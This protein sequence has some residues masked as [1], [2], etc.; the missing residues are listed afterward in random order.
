[1]RKR[2]YCRTRH[3]TLGLLFVIT[4]ACVGGFPSSTEARITKIVISRVESPTF[5]GIAFGDVGQYEK[6]VGRAFGEVDPNDPRNTVITDIALAPRNADG[7]VEYST[8]VYI[9]RPVDPS[10]GNHRIFFEI[11]QRGGNISF[12]QM[13]EAT[14]GG[15]DPTTAGDAG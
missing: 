10:R 3:G 7:M 14:T 9:M 1:M 8:D 5:E 12:G 4:L 11:T 6:L 15:N 2:E 13:N